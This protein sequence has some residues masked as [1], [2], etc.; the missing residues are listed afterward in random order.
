M[1]EL[2]S[3]AEFIGLT[4]ERAL[5]LLQLFGQESD[6]GLRRADELRGSVFNLTFKASDD[7]HDS[8]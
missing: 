6:D 8:V 5:C 2:A 4:Q 7:A 3:A 1:V